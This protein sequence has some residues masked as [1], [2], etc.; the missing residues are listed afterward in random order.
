M[1]VPFAVVFYGAL[2]YTSRDGSLSLTDF[3]KWLSDYD[4]K[5]RVVFTGDNVNPFSWLHV[6]AVKRYGMTKGEIVT[7]MSPS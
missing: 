7:A 5:N 4:T 1:L 3:G 6:L 2:F